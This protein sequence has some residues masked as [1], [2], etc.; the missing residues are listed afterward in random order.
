MSDYKY[1]PKKLGYEF[2]LEKLNEIENDIHKDSDTLK[3]YCI[4]SSLNFILEYFRVSKLPKEHR[5]KVA[6]ELQEVYE[7][8]AFSYLTR[9]ER[10]RFESLIESLRAYED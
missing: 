10:E 6:E 8:I 7:R 1:I 3:R 5:L 4:N 9:I 2:A